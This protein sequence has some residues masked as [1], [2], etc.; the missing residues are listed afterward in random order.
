MPKRTKL[1]HV[2][3]S[4]KA[5]MV[6]VGGKPVTNREAW[7]QGTVTMGPAALRAV[8]AKTV[9]KGD[10]VQVARLAGIQ[11]AKQT[12]SLI[13]LCHPLPLSHI[14]VD[15]TPI[16][17]GYR[18]DAR[19][20]DDRADRRGDG[21]A[22]GRL[23]S[24]THRVRHGEGGGQGHGDWRH[25]AGREGG[26]QERTLSPPMT[27][28]PARTPPQGA[29]YLRVVV[30]LGALTAMGPLAIDMYLPALPAIASDL[31]APPALVQAS[32]AAYFIGIALGQALYGPFSDRWGRKPA[33][34]LGL[35]VFALSSVACALTSEVHSADCVPLPSGPRW[36]CPARRAAGRGPRPLRPAGFG[37][38]TVAADSRDGAGADPGAPHRRAAVDHVGL[39]GDLLAA[40]CL[41]GDFADRRRPAAARKPAGACAPRAAAGRRAVDLLAASS[42]SLL[43]GLGVVGRDDLLG[44]AGLHLWLVVR[45]HRTLQGPPRTLRLLLR[46]QRD[47]PDRSLSGQRLAGEALPPEAGRQRRDARSRLWPG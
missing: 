26:R 11:A 44:P 31:Q 41:R 12:A 23:R 5:V 8:R 20:S 27:S 42:R 14:E 9:A 28:A 46:S 34:Y 6:D 22:D 45:L 4:G 35:G 32:L 16:A 7:A 18:I 21:S 1:S 3:S 25:R 29:D 15:L 33:L 17:S 10:V 38:C 24:R 2:D 13:P 36:L 30:I 39:A 47:W 40:R 19:V 37:A 43:H